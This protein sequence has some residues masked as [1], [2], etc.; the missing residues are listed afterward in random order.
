MSGPMTASRTEHGTDVSWLR[1]RGLV[2]PAPRAD[3]RL[4]HMLWFKLG[5]AGQLDRPDRAGLN[6]F[7]RSRFGA[8]W[9]A[10]PADID[11]LRDHNQIE[12]VIRAL[13]SWCEHKGI[14]VRRPE[15]SAE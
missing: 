10:A 6:A 3:L 8:A 4:I 11:M 15:S 12:A 13:K 5:Q 7:I 9:G 1:I 2:K 14:N